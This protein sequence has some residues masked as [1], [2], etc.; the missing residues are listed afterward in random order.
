MRKGIRSS[1]W[2]IFI[3]D[4]SLM[5]ARGMN[6]LLVVLDRGDLCAFLGLFV[7]AAYV[8]YTGNPNLTYKRT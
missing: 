2:G 5:Y 6:A 1:S 8:C 7:R 4:S 3:L